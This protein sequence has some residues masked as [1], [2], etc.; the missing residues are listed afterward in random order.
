M[1]LT[2]HQTSVMKSHNGSRYPEIIDYIHAAGVG[3]FRLLAARTA[4][5]HYKDHP[6]ELQTPGI[7]QQVVI[8]A[9]LTDHKS[10][11]Q[12]TSLSILLCID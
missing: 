7:Q 4:L 1:S 3:T 10:V 6:Q 8:S 5:H 9:G 11:L 12:A 2:V